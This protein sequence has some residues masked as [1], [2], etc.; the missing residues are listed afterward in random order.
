[1]KMNHVTLLIVAGTLGGIASG[2]AQT[3]ASSP[4]TTSVRPPEA[5]GA[6]IQFAELARDF[7]RLSSGDVVRHDFVFTN[8][9]TATLEI[10]DVRPGCGCTTAGSWD[11]R[12]EPG[13]TGVIP[14]Q[15]NSTGFNG[16]VSKT[17][18]VICN[19]PAQ[20]NVVLQ[21]KGLIWKPIEI[22]PAMAVFNVF[23]EGQTNDTRILRI[24]NHLDDPIELS[25]VKS[26]NQSFQAE[27]KT[28]RPG[29]EFELHVKAVP[30]Y[31]SNTAATVSVKTSAPQMPTINVNAYI[32]VQQAVIVAPA[33]ITVPTG[34]LSGGLS[35][36]VKILNRGT[37]ALV[38]SEPRVNSPGIEVRLQEVQP[39]QVFGLMVN[40]PAGFQTKPDK[41]I[42]VTVK[43]NHP[44][45]PLITVPVLQQ[46]RVVS[47]A[48]KLAPAK[49]SAAVTGK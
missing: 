33:Q 12:V 3:K 10:T 42:E 36:S 6:K 37:N 4:P 20:T 18:I 2:L 11:R 35:S 25:D 1:M 5:S 17:V 41:K 26:T 21:V 8:T 19:D 39:G 32:A 9:G 16:T 46:A 29:K 22:T 47:A 48:P 31:T 40:F 38:L 24:V 28:V 45:Y 7:G 15:F 34:R 23:S 13:K 43:S 30:P 44:K 49:P 27:L 14:V